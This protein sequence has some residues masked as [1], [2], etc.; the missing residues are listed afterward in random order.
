METSKKVE[1]VVAVGSFGAAVGLAFT[2]LLISSDHDIAS[3]VLMMCAQF[4]MLTATIFGIDYKFKTH[5]N[6]FR[7]Y[8]NKQSNSEVK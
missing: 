6:Y 4:L 5:E 2:S 3:G 1:Y 8:V 7:R